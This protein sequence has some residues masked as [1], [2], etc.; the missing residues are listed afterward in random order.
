[1]SGN[2]AIEPRLEMN[3]RLLLSVALIAVLFGFWLVATRP[4]CRDGFAVSL[5][6]RLDW[7]CVADGG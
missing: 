2:E 6:P 7:S 3:R 4:M 5:G 1:M